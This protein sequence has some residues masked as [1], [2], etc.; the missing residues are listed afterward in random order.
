MIAGK[1]LSTAT[2]S[3]EY[4][5]GAPAQSI[6]C[7]IPLFR[8]ERKDQR[9]LWP[10]GNSPD[11]NTLKRELESSRSALF[12]VDDR[13]GQ[14]SHSLRALTGRLLLRCHSSLSQDGARHVLWVDSI[15]HV[16]A[17]ERK[18]FVVRG[19][20]VRHQGFMLD[21]PVDLRHTLRDESE[22]P[23]DMVQELLEA[24]KASME[25][26]A[27]TSTAL[28]VD[29]GNQS[30][31]E[32]I[33]TLRVF[34]DAEHELEHQAAQ[35]EAGFT[36]HTV[37]PETSRSRF[38]TLVRFSLVGD[39]WQRLARQQPPLQ[40]LSVRLDDNEDLIVGVERLVN[41]D[42]ATDL[43]GSIADQRGALALPNSGTL[44]R[45]AM[46][47]LKRVRN[48]TLDTL[49]DERSM[50]PWL[51]AV[52]AGCHPMQPFPA[53][54][55]D[56]IATAATLNPSQRKAVSKGLGTPD[57]QLVLGPP[58]TGKT[59]VIQ[60]WVEKIVRSGG[61]VLVTSQNNK[62]VDNVLERLKRDPAIACVRLGDESRVSSSVVE[63]LIDN[64]AVELQKQLL[65]GVETGR[66][67]LS[68]L[69]RCLQQGLDSTDAPDGPVQLEEA[70][71]SIAALIQGSGAP[72]V[73]AL[74]PSAGPITDGH[75]DHSR[76]LARYRALSTEADSRRQRD[77]FLA[78]WHRFRAWMLSRS[79]ARTRFQADKSARNLRAHYCAA[80][81]VLKKI[82][83]RVGN[84]HQTLGQARQEDLYPLLI[85][86]VDVVGATCIGIN[87]NRQFREVGFDMTIV[88][89]AGQIQLHNIAV[90]LARAPRAIL[91][92]D[93]KQLPPVVQDEL[94]TE[95]S[96]RA[97]TLP[98]ELDQSLL[99][100]S[101]FES[102]WDLLPP[103]RKS[104]LDTQF[105]CPAV[106]SNYI[107]Q[108]FYEGK[109]FAAAGMHAKR[110]L[111]D[112]FSSPMVFVDTSDARPGTRCERSSRAS[113]RAEVLGNP[114]ESEIIA[115]L[116][117]L[118]CR[119]SP[120]TAAAGEI[121]IIVPYK[122]HVEEIQRRIE[123]DRHGGRLPG[124]TTPTGELV[125]SVDSYQGQER[126]LILF[127][128][129]RS[130]P[131]G[132]IGF[133]ADWRRLNVAMTR[134][135]RQLVMV[136]DLSTL[137]RRSRAGARDTD[138]KQAACLLRDHMQRSGQVIPSCKLDE[139]LG[140]D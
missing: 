128:F 27:A 21:S 4:S 116:L 42:G 137:T 55:L 67:L 31:A 123:R 83:R 140:A 25:D 26:P 104:M 16:N 23:E 107:S 75:L 34:V 110:P 62:A 108:A 86:L 90:P 8:N 43:I 56:D 112:C 3:I 80:I 71:R 44:L 61:R 30:K 64:R 113:D 133:L 33:E 45:V 87:T 5:L 72:A 37:T 117:R 65:G 105:R 91:V 97:E 101:W 11:W 1:G 131:A 84:W 49:R 2:D 100:K 96:L 57:L 74:G 7:R 125:A 136:G 10:D 66:E 36:Y 78:L 121:G 70:G 138:F 122:K 58:G 52:A 38:K 13:P 73:E 98:F 19:Q 115:R 119:H 60:T 126:D 28:A 48:S 99:R 17:F 46:D 41:R 94:V 47:V 129:T 59:T 106:I 18:Q 124:L 14:N 88:D 93:H 130:N 9:A 50:N 35:S 114:Y 92:G 29:D 89:E 68:A 103:S 111:L 24:L 135:K 54:S 20:P 12:I 139:V 32:L 51:T 6:E 85:S 15:R 134:T 81:D 95:V 109:Y 77:G 82:S 79:A 63:L 39:D 40:M 22:W 69:E 120:D 118:A 102:A 53:V 76:L 127:A 132:S